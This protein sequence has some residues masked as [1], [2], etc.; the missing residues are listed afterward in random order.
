MAATLR[1]D[2]DNTYRIE[3]RGRLRRSD[4]QELEREA[5]AEI[6]RSGAIRLLVTLNSFDGWDVTANWRDLGFYVRHGNDIER[7][8]IVG[9][10]RWRG[11]ALMFAGAGLRKAP[12]VFFEP[13]ES[14]RAEA[15]LA[16]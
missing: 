5:A 8:A 2:R 16:E 15:W 7:I 10:G 12:V 9:D 13:E 14:A 4:L 11:A 6:R 1:H 3:L